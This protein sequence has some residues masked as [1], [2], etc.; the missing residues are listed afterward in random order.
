MW[1]GCKFYSRA[2]T[3]MDQRRCIFPVELLDLVLTYAN[4]EDVYRLA[5]LYEQVRNSRVF[6]FSLKYKD[7]LGHAVTVASFLARMEEH[8]DIEWIDAHFSLRDVRWD[9]HDVLKE[10]MVQGRVDA[11]EWLL[12]TRRVSLKA[13]LRGYLTYDVSH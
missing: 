7:T 2:Y 5:L 8:S 3:T 9:D 1:V 10:M 12:D 13:L 11:L 4:A 6:Q